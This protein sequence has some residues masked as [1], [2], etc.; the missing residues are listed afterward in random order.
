MQQSNGGLYALYVYLRFSWNRLSF[1]LI[2]SYL[3]APCNKAMVAY[4]HCTYPYNLAE[5]DFRLFWS[6]PINLH[7]QILAQC[8]IITFLLTI[9]I[10]LQK[11]KIM[12]Q[13]SAICHV[14]CDTCHS[15]SLYISVFCD[16]SFFI[17]CHSCSRSACKKCNKVHLE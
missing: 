12:A 5:I 11:L 17:F 9:Y 1:I 3:P 4:M 13:T 16:I 7:N 15:C 8:Y 2:S 14:F 6:V 10:R